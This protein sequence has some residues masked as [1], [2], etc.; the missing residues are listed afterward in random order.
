MNLVKFLHRNAFEELENPPCRYP[1]KQKAKSHRLWWGQER[2]RR[3][4]GGGRR[5]KM[6]ACR[7]LSRILMLA[8]AVHTAASTASQGYLTTAARRRSRTII[9]ANMLPLPPF[10]RQL[11]PVPEKH[12]PGFEGEQERRWRART[13]QT[14][15]PCS[16][17][18]FSFLWPSSTTPPPPSTHWHFT[19]VPAS[20]VK[21]N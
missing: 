8:V 9:K 10:E 16:W 12:P 6:S 7:Y 11:N 5:R 17:D 19:V 18:A 20:K 21:V 2:E 4:G 1:V 13:K 3:G 15:T 14:S